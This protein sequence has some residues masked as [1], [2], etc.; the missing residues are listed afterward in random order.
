MTRVNGPTISEVC[1]NQLLTRCIHDLRLG[2]PDHC[3]QNHAGNES[4]VKTPLPRVDFAAHKP[5]TKDIFI[6]IPRFFACNTDHN[7][8]P[9]NEPLITM[10]H[11]CRSWRNVLLSIPNLWTQIDLSTPNVWTRLDLSASKSKQVETFLARSGKQ[12]LDIYQLFETPD[13]MEFFLPVTLRNTHRLRWLETVSFPPYL[14]DTLAQLTKPA[15]ELKHLEVVNGLMVNE[16]PKLP[17]TI[18]GGQFQKLASLSLE[19]LRVD[20]HDFNFPSLTRFSFTAGAN[21]S[22]QDLTS[23]FGRCSSLEFASPPIPNLQP[24]LP[25]NGFV[26]MP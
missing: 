19:F 2:L 20:L 14:E 10:T 4:V 26:S 8:F 13:Q 12:L 22:V 1:R 21:M 9:M 5:T 16:L 25:G 11:V 7:T 23:F 18:F 15:P 3:G 24:L 6:L 17:S